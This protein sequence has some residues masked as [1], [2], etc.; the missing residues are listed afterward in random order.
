MAGHRP[1]CNRVLIAS[2]Q[3]IGIYPFAVLQLNVN[4]EKREEFVRVVSPR[5]A[6]DAIS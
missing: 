2:E 1:G 5:T 4:R 6:G 3:S